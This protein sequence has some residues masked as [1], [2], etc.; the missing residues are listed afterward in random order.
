MKILILVLSCERP[1]YDALHEVQR[2]T[3]DSVIVDGVETTYYWCDAPA[4]MSKRLV[5]TLN[6]DAEGS[7]CAGWDFIFRTNSSS[8]VDKLR[9]LEHAHK[10]PRKWCYQGIDGD[11]FA[12]GSG[13]L[14]SRDVAEVLQ[15]DLLAVAGAHP[16]L[17]EDQAIGLCLVQRGVGVT[18]GARREDYWLLYFQQQFG[19]L[20]DERL[21][22]AYHIRCKHGSDR[23][24]DIEAMEHAH[25]IK[26][27]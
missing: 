27:A 25:R 2:R 9:L 1:P 24:K 26:T 20:L 23:A 14:M 3:W 6:D 22:D 15:R 19:V 17:I 8:Y 21:R 11:G 16:D 7:F 12:S 5:E 4:L 10:A 13:F 18:K